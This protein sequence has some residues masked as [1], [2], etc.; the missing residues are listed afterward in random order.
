MK[1]YSVAVTHPKEKGA[2]K[3][4]QYRYYVWASHPFEAREQ[5]EREEYGH[6][7]PA[8]RDALMWNVQE[9][10]RNVVSLP[11]HMVNPEVK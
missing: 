2:R 7:E 11:P 4:W 10:A 9:R 8:R 1:L 5:V 3:L 6:Y